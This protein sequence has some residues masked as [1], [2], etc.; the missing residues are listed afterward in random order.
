M[1]MPETTCCT[2]P[3]TFPG[4]AKKQKEKETIDT[5]IKMAVAQLDSDVLTCTYFRSVN[6]VTVTPVILDL[7]V[8]YT[9]EGGMLQL[10]EFIYENKN[11]SAHA[12]R[13]SCIVGN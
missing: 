1:F 2:F 5:I 11:N 6:R 3:K 4:T 8:E 7:I 13:S 9:P 10:A 12:E